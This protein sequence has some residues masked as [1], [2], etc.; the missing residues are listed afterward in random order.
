MAEQSS[1][2]KYIKCS[3]CSC[4]YHNNDDNI[5]N[6]VGHHRL[7]GTIKQTLCEV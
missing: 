2:D 5:K 7:R 3:R 4:K 6:D 1:D